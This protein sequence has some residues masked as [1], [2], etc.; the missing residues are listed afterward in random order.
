[1]FLEQLHPMSLQ[2]A[3]QLDQQY[4]IEKYA[5]SEK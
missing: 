1:M 5:L 2:G 4:F 3:Y